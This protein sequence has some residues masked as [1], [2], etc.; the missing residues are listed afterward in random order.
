MKKKIKKITMKTFTFYY[1]SFIIMSVKIQVRILV[2]DSIE[3]LKSAGPRDESSSPSLQR[4]K[5]L[6]ILE[7]PGEVAV[8]TDPPGDV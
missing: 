3:E 2:G 6:W 5:F 7:E 4:S 1:L 8:D